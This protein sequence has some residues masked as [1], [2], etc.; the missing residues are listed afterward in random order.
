MSRCVSAEFWVCGAAIGRVLA[1]TGQR[2]STSET[3]RVLVRGEQMNAPCHPCGTGTEFKMKSKIILFRFSDPDNTDKL[4][5]GE[6][7]EMVVVRVNPNDNTFRSLSLS[8]LPT[9]TS[10]LSRITARSDESA[11]LPPSVADAF[12]RLE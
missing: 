9:L 12:L 1:D 10:R 11:G 8:R 4:S 2:P 3:I 5:L 7:Y 6:N